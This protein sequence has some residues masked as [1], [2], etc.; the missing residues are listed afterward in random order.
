MKRASGLCKFYQ[1]WLCLAQKVFGH[2]WVDA[3]GIRQ[4]WGI[5]SARMR[6]TFVK[7]RT[8]IHRNKN[9]VIPIVAI[10]SPWIKK[11]TLSKGTIFTLWVKAKN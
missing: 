9:V 5:F 4:K 6:A 11:N 3:P 2:F 1:K 7:N 10:N 8:K